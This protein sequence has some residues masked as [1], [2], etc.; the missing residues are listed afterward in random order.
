MGE[1]STVN[2]RLTKYILLHL[3]ADARRCQPMTT[4]EERALS[5]QVSEAANAIWARAERRD[6]QDGARVSEPPDDE[7]R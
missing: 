4:T 6:R 3:D 1:L 7:R 5:E 2:A